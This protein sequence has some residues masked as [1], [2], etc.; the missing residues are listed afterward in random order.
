MPRIAFF[1]TPELAVFVLEELALAGT[2]PELVVTTPDKPA[3][4][5]LALTPPPTAAWAFAQGVPLLQTPTLKDPAPLAPLTAEPWDLFIVAAYNTIIP[6]WVLAL[7]AHGTLN[8]HPSLLPKLRGPSPIRSAL[9][10]DL[11]SEVGV[12]LILL[13]TEVDHGPL[14]ARH[15]LTP[16]TWPLPGRVLDELLFRAGGRLLAATLPEWL[17]GTRTPVPQDHPHAT[18]TRKF[19]K[20]D[21]E[22]DLTGDPYKT[23]CTYCAVDG[24]PGAYCFV[25]RGGVPNAPRMRVGISDAVYENG[26]FRIRRVVPEGKREMAYEDFV[27]G[28]APV[29][30]PRTL[31]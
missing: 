19:E 26:T 22:L 25:A 28:Y 30:L 15:P 3:G 20:R 29:F 6:A 2:K 23:Y 21:G 9:R 14:I 8:V 27:R 24:W 5:A 10:D 4:R 31:A 11:P 18:Y 17:A 16:P 12:S 13:D 7:P 1:G